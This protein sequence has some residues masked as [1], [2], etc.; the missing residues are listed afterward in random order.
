[1]FRWYL[2]LKPSWVWWNLW[3]ADGN[4]Y[5]TINLKDYPAQKWHTGVCCWV[6]PWNQLQHLYVFCYPQVPCKRL[7]DFWGIALKKDWYNIHLAWCRHAEK[8]VFLEPANHRLSCYISDGQCGREVIIFQLLNW[9]PL[10]PVSLTVALSRS[11]SGMVWAAFVCSCTMKIRWDQWGRPPAPNQTTKKSRLSRSSW[12]HLCCP[13]MRAD[14]GVPRGWLLQAEPV[15][16]TSH[17]GNPMVRTFMY[18]LW[19]TGCLSIWCYGHMGES[20]EAKRIRIS[21]FHLCKPKNYNY[22]S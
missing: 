11:G 6:S 20:V 2:R 18:I 7:T 12:K 15:G 16:S 9:D 10:L 1:M 17:A 21:F 19:W 8:G 13:W 4:V 3:S 14:W 22:L 5:L